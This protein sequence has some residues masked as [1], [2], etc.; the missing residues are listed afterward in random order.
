[1]V[2]YRGLTKQDIVAAQERRLAL[3]KK[4]WLDLTFPLCAELGVNSDVSWLRLDSF[5]FTIGKLKPLSV[6]TTRFGTEVSVLTEEN[7]LP[8][9]KKIN[10]GY[11][12]WEPLISDVFRT[13]SKYQS[14]L[15]F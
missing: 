2:N 1:L 12:D 8:K 9:E 11:Q 7:N 10:I 5:V 13:V 15:I 4:S 14:K 6:M 3:L